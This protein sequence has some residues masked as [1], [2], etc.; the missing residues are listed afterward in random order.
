MTLAVLAF[1]VVPVESEHPVYKH[2]YDIYIYK[3]TH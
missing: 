3:Y 1:E 2:I